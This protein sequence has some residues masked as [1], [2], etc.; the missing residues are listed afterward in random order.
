MKKKLSWQ[1]AVLIF[2]SLQMPGITNS[3]VSDMSMY[4]LTPPPSETP[5]IN[6]A[7]VFGARPGSEFIFTVVASGKRPMAFMAENLPKGLKINSET[8][9]IT[10]KINK[11][12]MYVVKLKA[13]NESGIHVHILKIIIGDKIALTP[14]MGWNSWNCWGNTVSQEKVLSSAKALVNKGLI[15]YGWNYINIDDG[16]QGIRG[17][18]YNAIVPNN[19]FPNMKE[20]ADTIHKMGL[21][22][23]IYSAPWVGTYAGHIGSYADNADGTY[24]TI[25]AGKHNEFHRLVEPDNRKN[26]NHSKFS[27][28]ENDTKQF[29]DWD[30]DYLKYDWDPNDYYNTKEMHDA[31]RKLKRD[32]I[33]SISNSAPY[34]DAPQWAKYTNSWRTTGDI[35]DS[36]ESVSKIGFNQDRWAPFNGTGHWADPDM[37]VVGMVGWGSQLH[38]SK[39]TADEQYTHISLWSLLA[40]PLLIGCD[41]AQLDDFT[42]N[43]LC[44]YEVNEVNQ[45]PLGYQA[46]TISNDTDCVNYAKPLED[47][48]MAVGMFNKGNTPRQ[49][50][51]TFKSIGVR[52]KQNI[53]DLWRQKEIGEYTDM[54]ST[55]VPPHG[56]VLVKVYPG[57]GREQ[58]ITRNRRL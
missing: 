32:V 1:M 16:W 10:G 23:G 45:D 38:Y 43:L 26:W 58:I 55:L 19:K 49:L 37:L 50:S 5:R 36:W 46:V 42:I 52:G 8:G 22:L 15:N 47:G 54:F 40:A 20:L 53:R 57:N 14:P 48:S 11:K 34:A 33:Y 30:I 29:S 31:L 41:V 17:G 18:K 44:N 27:F 25:K 2:L 51:F 9:R 4:I 6:A 56:V 39:L 13:K 3:Q 12:G 28:V 7:K 35:V 21:K 24:E